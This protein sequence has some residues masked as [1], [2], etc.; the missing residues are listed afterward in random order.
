MV[1]ICLIIKDQ[2]LFYLLY[3]KFLGK[4]QLQVGEIPYAIFI[5]L[6][7]DFDTIDYRILIC[8]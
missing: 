8:K 5:D 6:S 4:H 7:K 2:N 3:I 1:H